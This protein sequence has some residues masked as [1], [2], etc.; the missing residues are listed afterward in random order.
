M[1]SHKP[2]KLSMKNGLKYEITWVQTSTNHNQPL[3]IKDTPNYFYP[4]VEK[5]GVKYDVKEHALYLNNS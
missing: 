3:Y 5:F 4:V 2:T 1:K